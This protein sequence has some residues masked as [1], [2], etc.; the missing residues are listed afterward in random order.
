MSYVE[1]VKHDAKMKYFDNL[2]IV[3]RD[4][5]QQFIF[6]FFTTVS[7]SKNVRKERESEK[8]SELECDDQR[9]NWG[10]NVALMEKLYG[11]DWAACLFLILSVKHS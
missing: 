9:R 2:G 11:L 10:E 8:D 4:R 6:F 7:V 5:N 3:V 1:A